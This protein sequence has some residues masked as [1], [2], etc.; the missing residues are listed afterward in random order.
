[1]KRKKFIM[2]GLNRTSNA[3]LILRLACIVISKHYRISL[4]DRHRPLV[5][6]HHGLVITRCL[7]IMKD[8]CCRPPLGGAAGQKMG[9]DVSPG[10]QRRPA[11]QTHRYYTAL[12]KSILG[13]SQR[14]AWPQPPDSKAW[15]KSAGL[16]LVG[17]AGVQFWGVRHVDSNLVCSAFS[18]S[19]GWTLVSSQ[20]FSSEFVIQ[21]VQKKTDTIIFCY[22]SEKSIPYLKMAHA[23][24]HKNNTRQV[25]H[26]KYTPWSVTAAPQ[27]RCSMWATVHGSSESDFIHKRNEIYHSIADGELIEE[28]WFLSKSFDGLFQKLRFCTKSIFFS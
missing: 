7:T 23:C 19:D 26:G 20:A 14:S 8:S 5:H 18:L 9:G 13:L 10:A 15:M 17:I 12:R 6:L 28:K 25:S 21:G 3:H 2:S 11:A 4:S 24:T 1:M 22:N 16:S 27:S